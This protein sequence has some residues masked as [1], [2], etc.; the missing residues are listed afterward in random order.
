[1]GDYS[2]FIGTVGFGLHISRDGGG[3]WAGAASSEPP[4]SA[5]G[6][7]EGNV[8]AL[9]VYPDNPHRLLA[10]TDIW[11]LYRSDDNGRSGAGTVAAE[12]FETAR[13][14]VEI[15][16]LA[17]DP[18]DTDTIYVGTRPDGFRERDGGAT[19]DRL[20]FTDRDAPLWPPRTTVIVVDPATTVPC[21]RAWRWTACTAAWTA[22]TPGGAA[23]RWDRNCSTTT[24][25]A[26][27][28]ATAQ[29]PSSTP[30]ARWDSPPAPTT[31]PVGACTSSLPSTTSP[32]T[33]T[34]AA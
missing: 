29:A 8:R 21:G 18:E 16:S 6:G 5:V 28:S 13:A 19:W 26:W 30:P 23:R 17:I 34:A 2:I 14:P 11:G 12:G 15:W 27:A 24:C 9:A 25:T 31:A 7:L 3:S 4:P 33:P 1:M 20:T 10:G 32:G 22:A